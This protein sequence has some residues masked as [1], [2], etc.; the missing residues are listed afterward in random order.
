MWKCWPWDWWVE[1]QILWAAGIFS[2]CLP[3]SESPATSLLERDT[4]VT[5]L[6]MV[7]ILRRVYYV[8]CGYIFLKCH[9]SFASPDWTQSYG[10][11]AAMCLRVNHSLSKTVLKLSS[12]FC[13]AG[14]K[15][16][17]RPCCRSEPGVARA[18]TGARSRDPDR[19]G[20]S[21]SGGSRRRDGSAAWCL[22][23]K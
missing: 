23:E 18:S 9:R 19:R 15:H 10:Y 22:K 2:W 1:D 8:L 20:G 6:W 5:S 14:G 13:L 11:L 4:D 16:S 3:C 7:L 17:F 12:P 21:V